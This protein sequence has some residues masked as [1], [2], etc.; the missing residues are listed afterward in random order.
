MAPVTCNERLN[1]T[2]THTNLNMLHPFSSPRPSPLLLCTLCPLNLKSLPVLSTPESL[3]H[4]GLCLV[5]PTLLPSSFL[6][7][8]E[9]FLG[10][11]LVPPHHP[12]PAPKCTLLFIDLAQRPCLSPLVLENS[13]DWAVSLV[14]GSSANWAVSCWLALEPIVSWSHTLGKAVSMC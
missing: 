8:Q 6:G 9:P 13:A 1:A 14:L 5:V 4:F 11:D 12:S 10:P 7:S 2:R 3:P